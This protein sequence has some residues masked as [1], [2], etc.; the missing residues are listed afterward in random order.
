MPDV[1][2]MANLANEGGKVLVGALATG[3]VGM[4]K[5][6]PTLW[7]RAG[8]GAEELMVAE[9]ER[10]AA[11][12]ADPSEDTHAAQSRVATAWEDRLSLLL[13]E[14]P[15]A[16]EELEDILAEIRRESTPMATTTQ[17]VTAS[18]QN[19]M[20]Q[21]VIVGSI[22][23]YGVASAPLTHESGAEVRWARNAGGDAAVGEQESD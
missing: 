6:V 19:S 1:D 2:I 22:N 3:L 8:K 4:A 21:G 16:K 14:Y 9:M 23:N 5:K 13:A 10:S 15:D 18:G 12:L 7:R 20:A 17:H 11:E